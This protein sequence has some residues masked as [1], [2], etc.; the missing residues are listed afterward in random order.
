MILQ[1]WVDQW[2]LVE[3]NTVLSVGD[4]VAWD[5]T[6]MDAA[7]ATAL[8]GESVTFDFQLDGYAALR[9][10]DTVTSVVGTIVRIDSVWCA[11]DRDDTGVVVPR[12]GAGRLEY[13]ESTR[14]TGPDAP[15]ITPRPGDEHLYGF[16][17]GIS[18]AS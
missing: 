11:Q 13:F 16:R 8:V 4:T 5:L 10:V 2:Q 18:L 17:I 12:A 1:V 14:P 15:R 7:W 3:K 9:G 6:A